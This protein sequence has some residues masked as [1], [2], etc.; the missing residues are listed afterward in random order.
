MTTR[1]EYM[2]YAMPASDHIKGE[3]QTHL[4][5]GTDYHDIEII[6]YFLQLSQNY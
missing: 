3:A 4:A 1:I 2:L 6:M 5:Y